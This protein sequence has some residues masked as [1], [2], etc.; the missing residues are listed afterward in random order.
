MKKFYKT[1][2]KNFCSETKKV[3]SFG[4]IVNG[5]KK[6]FTSSVNREDLS[7]NKEAFIRLRVFLFI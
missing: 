4:K 1:N 3:S 6:I 2:F 5:F 7:Y